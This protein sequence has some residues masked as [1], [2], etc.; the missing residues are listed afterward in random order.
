[1]FPFSMFMVVEAGSKFPEKLKKELSVPLPDG[2][3]TL[4]VRGAV[5]RNSGVE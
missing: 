4:I 2:S 3:L 5:D 1:M